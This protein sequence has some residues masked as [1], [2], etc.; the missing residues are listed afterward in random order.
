MVKFFII[1]S[2]C[3]SFFKH[4]Q[5][6]VGFPLSDTS[7]FW[8]DHVWQFYLDGVL[9]I[10]NA[11]KSDGG[12]YNLTAWN[13]HGDFTSSISVHIDVQYPSKYV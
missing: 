3:V 6:D 12:I 4:L 2:W 1:I 13:G 9:T 8:T 5:K 10:L 11:R 7:N